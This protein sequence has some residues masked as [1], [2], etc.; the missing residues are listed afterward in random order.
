MIYSSGKGFGYFLLVSVSI[1]TA[2]GASLSLSVLVGNGITAY[3]K[4]RLLS[5][6]TGSGGAMSLIVWS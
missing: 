1:S 2:G 4:G 6:S 5:L 3:V